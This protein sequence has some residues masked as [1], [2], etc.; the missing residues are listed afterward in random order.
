[1]RT[2]LFAWNPKKWNWS[3]LEQSIQQIEQTGRASEKWSVI[4]HKKI[5][6][7]DRA[8]L[9]RL[10]KEPKGIMGSGFVVSPVFLSPHWD[11]SDRLVNRVMIDFEVLL[12]SEKEPLLNFEKLKNG[13]LQKVNWTPQSSGIEVNKVVSEELEAVWFEFL[14]T[15]K[16]RHNPFKET[17]EQKQKVY[18]EGTPNQ[19]LVTKYERNPFARKTCIEYYGL[20]CSVCKFNFE[21]RY[22]EL[23]KGFIHVHHLKQIAEIGKKCEVNPIKDLRPVCPNCHAMIHKRKT[24]YSINELK[25]KIELTE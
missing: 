5:Q 18:T 15:Q 14:N 24:P 9:I 22:G 8:F 1:M 16:I 7:G 13:N 11:G 6:P 21:E 3:T 19:V 10:G 23:G 12:N 4:S 17:E 20:S 25:E 2:F